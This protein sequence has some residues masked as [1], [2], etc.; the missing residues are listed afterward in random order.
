[1]SDPYQIQ[2]QNVPV[3]ISLSTN[4]YGTVADL[5]VKTEKH[6]SEKFSY[7]SRY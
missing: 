6:S 2:T 1:M 7:A 3:S 5:T 4:W